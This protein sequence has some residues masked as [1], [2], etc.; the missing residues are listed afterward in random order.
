MDEFFTIISAS[1]PITLVREVRA[2]VGPRKFS[3]LIREL[4][5]DWLDR[6]KRGAA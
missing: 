5:T 2:K 3:A 4:L 1:V 6:E